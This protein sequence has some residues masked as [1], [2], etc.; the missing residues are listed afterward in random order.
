VTL[1]YALERGIEAEFQLED[2]EL[3]T[4]LMPDPDERGR[5]LFTESAEGGAGILRRIASEP[6]ALARA[7][8]KALEICHFDTDGADNKP[9]CVQACY[10][11][12]LSYGNQLH[13][14]QIDRHL[15][16]DF[17]MRL[18]RAVTAQKPRVK[19]EDLDRKSTSTLERDFLQ[20]LK[21][22]GLRLPT[23]AQHRISALKVCPDFAYRLDNGAA[24]AVFTDGPAHDAVSVA[25]RDAAA[26]ERLLDAGWEVVR[27]RY[28]DD[29]DEI[30]RTY[31]WVFG[32]IKETVQ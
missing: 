22:R 3:A 8:Q 17:L 29:W 10:D 14:Q 16:R 2:S 18:A 24:V 20:Y 5:T 32:K 7:A 28:D 21:A 31:E 30:V 13:H 4:E 27:F 6:D 25:E 19:A 9:D 15:V 12:L 23:E 26:V 1:Q 11:C